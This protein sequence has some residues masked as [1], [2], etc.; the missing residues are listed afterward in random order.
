MRVHVGRLIGDERRVFDGE[1]NHGVFGGRLGIVAV[2]DDAGFVFFS[3]KAHKPG[4]HNP[5]SYISF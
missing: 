5:I 2:A 1:T 4:Y 3:V